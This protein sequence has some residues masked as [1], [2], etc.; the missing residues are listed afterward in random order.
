LIDRQKKILRSSFSCVKPGGFM[1]YSTCSP[2]DE[3][4]QAVVAWLLKKE[5]G[6]KIIPI[7]LYDFPDQWIT[8]EGYIKVEN[9]R[10]MGDFFVAKIFKQS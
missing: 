6:A 8:K 3:E 2:R 1:I 9:D 4:N 10:I 7:T 5:E